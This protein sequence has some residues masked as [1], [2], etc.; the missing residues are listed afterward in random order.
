MKLL[1][2][3]NFNGKYDKSQVLMLFKMNNFDEGII[4]LCEDLLLQEEL[5]HFYIEKS[6]SNWE[7]YRSIVS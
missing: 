4:Y 3:Q 5:L 7:E 1:K 6:K 2:N